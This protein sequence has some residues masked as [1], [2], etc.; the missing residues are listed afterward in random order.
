MPGVKGH[1]YAVAAIGRISRVDYP[2]SEDTT[3]APIAATADT[4]PEAAV[5]CTGVAVL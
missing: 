5:G 1:L 2:Y 3:D 4:A